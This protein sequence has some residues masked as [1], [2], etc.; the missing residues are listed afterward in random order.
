MD[1]GI[2]YYVAM[3]GETPLGGMFQMEGPE[4]EGVADH[5]YAYIAVDD[6]DARVKTALENGATLVRPI[7]DVAG[8]GRIGLIVDPCGAAVGW[9]TPAPGSEEQN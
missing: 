3:D 5:W 6:V 7:F 8:I 1:G 4:H 2:T 9:M